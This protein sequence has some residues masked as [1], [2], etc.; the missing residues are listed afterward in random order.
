MRTN[1]FR[2]KKIKENK[3]KT[4]KKII[5]EEEQLDN[6]ILVLYKKYGCLAVLFFLL[7]LLIILGI[8][9]YTVANLNTNPKGDYSSEDIAFEYGDSN[10]KLE[11]EQN[12]SNWIDKYANVY[13]KEGIIFVVKSFEV[14]G[15]IVTYYSDES[16]KLVRSDGT[17]VRISRLATGGYGISEDGVINVNSKRKGISISKKLE[18]DSGT[19]II[20]YSDGSAEIT[21]NGKT[22]LVRNSERIKIGSNNVELDKVVP[23]G[24]SYPNE[25]KNIGNWKL[26][27][28]TDGTVLVEDGNNSYVVRNSEDLEI[29]TNG[30]SFPNNNAATVVKRLELDDGTVI[31]YYSDGSALIKSYYDTDIMVRESGDIILN[32]KKSFWEI[33][34]DEIAWAVS[35]KTTPTGDEITYYDDGSAVIRYKDGSSVYVSENSNIKYDNDGNIKEVKEVPNKETK[36]IKTPNGYTVTDFDNGKSRIEDPNGNYYIVDTKD[37]IMDTDGNLKDDESNTNKYNPRKDEPKDD[38]SD[39][40][41]EPDTPDNPDDDLDDGK[42]TGNIETIE[43]NYYEFKVNNDTKKAVKYKIVLEES[44]NYEKLGYKDKI[45]DAKYIKYDLIVEDNYFESIALNGDIWKY[46][47]KTNYVLYEGALAKKSS[48]DVML[49]IYFD[50]KD[51]DNEQQDRLFLGTIKLYIEQ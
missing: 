21:K 48:L 27:Y 41:E 30:I 34:E 18:L 33:L 37:I 26:T 46:N 8:I 22:I 12:N 42:V 29:G 50:Y 20:Y 4:E 47:D 9:F 3:D 14:P 36:V 43:K 7:L 1:L 17:I 24:S 19:V 51:L 5:L 13:K 32:G 39:D 11:G 28:Y 31:I 6:P 10:V 49:K 44:S 38:D 45:L 15:G 35:K 40:D 2:T 23:S 16:S 25:I